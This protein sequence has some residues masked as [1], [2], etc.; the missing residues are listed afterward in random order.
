MKKATALFLCFILVLALSSAAYGEALTFEAGTYKHNPQNNLSFSYEAVEL[1]HCIVAIGDL[2]GLSAEDSA[3]LAARIEEDAAR[4]WNAFPGV[5]FVKPT[6]YLAGVTGRSGSFAIG[7]EAFILPNELFLDA[8]L[9]VL[10]QAMFGKDIPL[11]LAEGCAAYAFMMDDMDFDF[12]CSY[13]IALYEST[14]EQGA[15]NLLPT[16]FSPAF[17]AEDDRVG[18]QIL[19]TSLVMDILTQDGPE[20]LTGEISAERMAQWRAR[21]GLPPDA[22][23]DKTAVLRE[24]SYSLGDG[25][26]MHVASLHQSFVFNA[27]DAMLT[28]IAAW[29]EFLYRSIKGRDSLIDYLTENTS[30]ENTEHFIGNLDIV[31]CQARKW[32]PDKYSSFRYPHTIRLYQYIDYSHEMVHC[33]LGE[34]DALRIFREGLCIYFDLLLPQSYYAELM[35][36]CAMEPDFDSRWSVGYEMYCKTAGVPTTER[37]DMRT[38]IDTLAVYAFGGSDDAQAAAAITSSLRS[39]P[40]YQYIQEPGID[41]TYMQGCSLMYYLI[42]Q[43]GLDT[44]LTHVRTGQTIMDVFGKPFNMLQKEW[45]M[46]LSREYGG[47]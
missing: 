12:F 5:P 7:S 39:Q 20:A 10:T 40:S 11:W 26:D 23:P 17:N 45:R 43:Y 9:T 41:L 44:V 18:T 24:L 14:V 38:W 16:R 32:A 22:D 30:P 8:Y 4:L 36:Q 28:D 6:V 21:V 46:Y 3:N 29:E 35:R 27:G 31:E 19:A 47:I 25:Y 42:D 33:M 13:A 37:F 34:T 15:L 1:D 2:Q